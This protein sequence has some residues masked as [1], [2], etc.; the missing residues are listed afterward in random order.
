[1]PAQL[2]DQLPSSS[3]RETAC[4]W[5]MRV[6]PIENEAELH[7]LADC[8]DRLAQRVPFRGWTWNECW[9]RHY[10]DP[11]DRLNV[12]AVEDGEATFA[13]WLRCTSAVR[14]GWGEWYVF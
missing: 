14:L 12:L 4:G 6:V 3:T 2:P 7:R 5:R 11:H 10:R 9:W 8:W 13:A 1:M